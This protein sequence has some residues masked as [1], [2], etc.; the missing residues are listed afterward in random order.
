MQ[1]ITGIDRN[2]T[3]FTTLETQIA[4]NNPVRVIEAFAE[5]LDCRRY[6]ISPSTK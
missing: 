5:K 4:A 2:Q 1:H 6:D 3:S